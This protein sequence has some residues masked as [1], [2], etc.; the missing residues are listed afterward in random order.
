[1]RMQPS[2]LQKKSDLIEKLRDVPHKPGVYLMKDRLNRI[3]YVGKARD[4]RKR[5]G[6]HFMPSR[7][8]NADLKTQALLDSVWDFEIHLVRNEPEALL[9]EGKLI[10]DYRP[11][12]NI[13][14]RDDK[15]FLLVKV[16]LS[17]P[18]PRFQLTRL[19]KDD[20]CRY[21]G[22]FAHA[23]ALRSTLSWMRKRF[24]IRSCRAPEPGEQ[25]YRRCLDHII[26]NCSAPC[27]RKVSLEEYHQRVLEACEFLDGESR[28]LLEQLE[29][30][31]KSAAEKLDFERAAQ[32]RNML[33]DLRRT[34][35]PTRRFTR[36]SLP[37]AVDPAADLQA[38]AD[39]LLLPGPPRIM[40]CFDISNISTTHVVASMV[41]FKDGVPDKSNYRRYRIRTV[42]GQD[43]F[44]SMAEVVR[45]RYSRILL[46]TKAIASDLSEFNQEPVE[47]AVRR[48]QSL[49]ELETGSP[50][51][52]ET[53]AVEELEAGP[54]ESV[55]T[56]PLDRLET[57]AAD[58]LEV[59]MPEKRK[60]G[61]E[62]LVRLPDLIIVDGG[63][64]QLNAACRELQR[65][66]LSERPII[67]LAKEFE[68][69][70]RPSRP[71][72]LRLP[73]DSGA[74]QL[75]QRIRDEAHRFANGY[76]QLLM[77]KRIAESILDECPGVSDSRKQALLAKFGSVERLRKASIEDIAAVEG[78]S[79]KLAETIWRFLNR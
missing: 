54:L 33:E 29:A 68:E 5:L 4:L 31:M 56:G 2:V 23:G 27:I 58:E 71:L 1:M 67:G 70:Y 19:K 61:P 79:N 41:C 63:K 10:K 9:L 48:A 45:R 72:P 44:A 17:D 7:R 39:A 38:L 62:R 15:R 20:G 66:G 25:D 69:I 42:E 57:S 6:Q 11:K 28:E 12:Y 35:K 34:T 52:I 3:I 24:G 22:P 18:I 40:E 14:F 75:L 37:S 46:E 36:G 47:D 16:N 74:L 65:L 32:I 60:S 78:I 64:G 8:A 49:A 13:S 53:E 59:K 21:F 30:E 77:K 43:D 73:E 76:H 50:D 55:D 26:K 51:N